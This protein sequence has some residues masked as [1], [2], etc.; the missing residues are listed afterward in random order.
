MAQETF[1]SHFSPSLSH[2]HTI[3]LRLLLRPESQSS[4]SASASVGEKE[5]RGGGVKNLFLITFL[6]L[7]SPP[8]PPFAALSVKLA[9]RAGAEGG[10]K[11]SESL[12]GGAGGENLRRGIRRKL[13][14]MSCRT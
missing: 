9:S 7:F 6:S 2:S 8:A 12:S 1:V 3:L 13:H 10:G 11:E 5:G 4:S 14:H